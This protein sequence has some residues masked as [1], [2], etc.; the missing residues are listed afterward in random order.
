MTKVEEVENHLLRALED[1]RRMGR[2]GSYTWLCLLGAIEA[3]TNELVKAPCV[4]CG[5]PY[6]EHDFYR[7]K[8]A[9][10][11]RMPCLLLKSGFVAQAAA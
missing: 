6:S 9:P 7:P 11:P 10:V 2:I 8:S 5:K 4:W 1:V 3:R